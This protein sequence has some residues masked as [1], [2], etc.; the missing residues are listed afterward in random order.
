MRR[1]P[2]GPLLTC[3]VALLAVAGCRGSTRDSAAAPAPTTTVTVTVT[4]TPTADAVE[5]AN[6]V[7]KLGSEWSAGGMAT[8]EPLEYR[9]GAPGT[10]D[11]SSE[12]WD[13]MLVKTCID[14]PEGS[15][16]SWSPWTLVDSDS[17]L[18]EASGETYG[19]FLAPQYPFAGDRTFHEGQCA[20][21]WIYFGVP[22]DS[23]LTQ[24]TYANEAGETHTWRLKG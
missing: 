22:K 21:G 4:A 1:P 19:D 6:D 10:I 20:K 9:R 24:V 23:R 3:C 8:I 7:S 11:V 15:T 16:L 17:G 14:D 12:R 5:A 2:L 18:Y 13:A